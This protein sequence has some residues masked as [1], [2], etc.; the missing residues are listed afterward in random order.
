MITLSLLAGLV[1]AFT[2]PG[3]A[4]VLCVLAAIGLFLA[5]RVERT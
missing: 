2:G 5:E 1:L 4:A 3:W